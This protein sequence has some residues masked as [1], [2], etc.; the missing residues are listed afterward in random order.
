MFSFFQT[1]WLRWKCAR[2][3]RR[4]QTVRTAIAEERRLHGS[5]RK[6]QGLTIRQ[7]RRIARRH[8]RGR[9]A[10][11]AELTRRLLRGVAA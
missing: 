3:E 7:L 5:S 1:L 6:L 9:V 8:P 11:E 4:L 2:A 10:A